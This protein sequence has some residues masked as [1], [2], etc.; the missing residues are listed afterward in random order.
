VFGSLDESLKFLGLFGAAGGNVEAAGKAIQ[1]FL[2][3]VLDVRDAWKNGQDADKNT[4]DAFNSLGLNRETVQNE[5]IKIGTLLTTALKNAMLDGKLDLKEIQALNFLLG[6]K[7]GTDMALTNTNA[8]AGFRDLDIVLKNATGTLAKQAAV[9]DENVTSKITQAWNKMQTAIISSDAWKQGELLFRDFIDTVTA[10]ING[11]WTLALTSLGAMG[12]DIFRLLLGADPDTVYKELVWWWDNTVTPS[13]NAF[14]AS[15]QSVD[16]FNKTIGNPL[17]EW[18]FKTM[19]G[20]S[21]SLLVGHE[22]AA[23]NN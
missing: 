5:S 3:K 20:A 4:I 22:C 1:L 2:G 23:R 13:A 14:L 18:L 10:A 19:L 8:S 6:D 17:G 9:M 16:S 7:V 11:D 21:S 15:D 12:N